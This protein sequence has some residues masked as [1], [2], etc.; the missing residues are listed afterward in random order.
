MAK[1]KIKKKGPSSVKWEDDIKN[2]EN[3]PYVAEV[4]FNEGI[5]NPKRVTQE[6]FNKRYGVKPINK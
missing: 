4:A 3:K 2:P 6:Q 5:K 1:V